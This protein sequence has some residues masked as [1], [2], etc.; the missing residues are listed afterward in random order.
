[1]NFLIYEEKLIF[2][3]I[4]VYFIY[5][6]FEIYIV[7]N[8]ESCSNVTTFIV[9]RCDLIFFNCTVILTTSLLTSTP[10]VIYVRFMT[11]TSG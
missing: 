7:R 5:M 6:Y 2:F 1:M 3:F 9:C 11:N 8:C 10:M 4:S